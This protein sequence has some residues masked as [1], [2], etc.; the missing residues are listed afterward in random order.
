MTRAALRACAVALL[1]Q[2]VLWAFLSYLTPDF[3][4]RRMDRTF[5]CY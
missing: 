2:L 1:V 5:L 4:G 3:Y